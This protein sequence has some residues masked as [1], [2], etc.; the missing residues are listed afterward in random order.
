MVASTQWSIDI[1]SPMTDETIHDEVEKN[2]QTKRTIKDS[3]TL[4]Y[5]PLALGSTRNQKEYDCTH[6]YDPPT[7]P[8]G[9]QHP[10]ALHTTEV[11][12]DPRGRVREKSE[13]V[14][15]SGQ[16]LEE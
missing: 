1:P 9:P 10:P 16:C 4:Q 15:V 11:A 3:A 7:T 12:F 2:Q 13:R 6:W 14:P 8:K 5:V